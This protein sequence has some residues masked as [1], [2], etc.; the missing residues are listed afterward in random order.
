MYASLNWNLGFLNAKQNYVK[1]HYFQTNDSN[2]FGLESFDLSFL[3]WNF[4]IIFMFSKLGICGHSSLIPVLIVLSLPPYT[5][6]L[7]SFSSMK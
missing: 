4:H 2:G 7:V 5:V 1:I 3:Q 6:Y